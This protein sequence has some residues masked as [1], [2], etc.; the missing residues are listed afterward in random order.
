VKR[1]RRS[2]R[3][4]GA[5]GPDLYNVEEAAIFL[6]CCERQLRQ[7]MR[8]NKI[9]YRRGPGGIRFTREDLMERLRPIGGRSSPSSPKRGKMF[10]GDLP[11][12]ELAV[13]VRILEEILRSE[14]LQSTKVASLMHAA[15]TANCM[16]ISRSSMPK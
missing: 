4:V 16:P 13:A 6:D 9:T 7:E 2:D 15:V 5:A 8:E 10:P 1:S 3:S 11:I 12:F 14:G